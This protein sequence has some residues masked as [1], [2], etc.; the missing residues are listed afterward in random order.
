MK[1]SQIIQKYAKQLDVSDEIFLETM[2]FATELPSNVT[3]L[4]IDNYLYWK[5]SREEHLKKMDDL[6]KLHLQVPYE[7]VKACGVYL[8]VKLFPSIAMGEIKVKYKSL[9]TRSEY[10]KPNQIYAGK[11]ITMGDYC[12]VDGTHSKWERGPLCDLDDNIVFYEPESIR[13]TSNGY[14]IAF[15]K[16]DLVV[17]KVNNP[18]LL[19]SLGIN[20][21][22]TRPSNDLPYR[23]PYRREELDKLQLSLDPEVVNQFIFL[24]DYEKESC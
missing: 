11:V 23:L 22:K 8:C 14:D 2:K 6:A 7:E 19:G 24:E 21:F 1:H 3:Q 10:R 9:F 17:C 16:D 18:L 4:H 5:S 15:V 13:T 12:Y 20:T